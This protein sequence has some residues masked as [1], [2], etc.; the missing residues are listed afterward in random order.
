MRS[1]GRMLCSLSK[2]ARS[3]LVIMM[4]AVKVGLPTRVQSELVHKQ[5]KSRTTIYKSESE[6]DS[7]LIDWDSS[8]FFLQVTFSVSLLFATIFQV[9]S[10]LILSFT[11]F[12]LISISFFRRSFGNPHNGLLLLAALAMVLIRSAPLLLPFLLSSVIFVSPLVCSGP[13][14]FCVCHDFFSISFCFLMSW[15]S[16][17]STKAT[18]FFQSE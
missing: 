17:A 4:M 9:P 16:A 13:R 15:S 2:D 6:L 11:T 12:F 18:L 8:N 7:E 3:A 14:R 1:K 5:T 10:N